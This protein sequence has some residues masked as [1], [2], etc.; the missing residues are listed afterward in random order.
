MASS[1]DG[2][3]KSEPK[4]VAELL[5]TSSSKPTKSGHIEISY[6]LVNLLSEQLYQS[7]AKAIEELVVNAYDADASCCWLHVPDTQALVTTTDEYMAILDDGHG[8]SDDELL[9]LWTIG[10]S[11]K[12]VG[13]VSK[14]ARRYIGKFGIGKLAT[15]SIGKQLTFISRVNGGPIQGVTVDFSAFADTKA[16]TIKT[17]PLPVWKIDDPSAFQ[18]T[19]LFSKVLSSLSIPPKTL[20]KPHWTLAIVE[21]LKPKAQQ[22]TSKKLNWVLSTALPLSTSFSIVLNG[23]PVISAKESGKK[24]AYFSLSELPKTRLDNLQ[25]NTG[26]EWKISKNKLHSDTFPNGLHGIAFVSHKSLQGKSEDLG[27]SYG[28]FVKINNRL[29]NENDE[30]FGVKPKSFETWF[31]FHATVNADDLNP[32]IMASR[33]VVEDSVEKRHLQAVLN[34]IYNEA[35][36]RYQA[37]RDK[38]DDKSQKTKREDVREYVS[39]RMIEEPLA[40]ALIA[41]MGQTDWFYLRGIDDAARKQIVEELYDPN[42][43]Y[44]STFRYEKLGPNTPIFRYSPDTRIF[45]LND[46]H[47]FVREHSEDARARLV[48]EDLVTA[49]LLLEAHL[50]RAGT[51]DGIVVGVLSSRDVLLRNLT[52]ERRY[53]LKSIATALRDAAN[54]EHDLE[55]ALI[56]AARTLGFVAKHVSGAGEPDGTA[57]FMDYP[58]GET[59]LVLEAK[60][61]KN[62]PS[63]GSIDFAGL[64]SHVVRQKAQG[65]LLLAP[66][67]PGSTKSDNEASAR[68]KQQRIS[69]WTIEQMA[70]VIENSETRRIGARAIRDIVLRSFAPEDVAVDVKKLLEEPAWRH[71]EL[72]AAIING[73]RSLEGTAS[74]AQRDT[75]MIVGVLAASGM[76]L[77]REEVRLA[78]SEL[79]AASKGAAHFSHDKDVLIIHTSLDE[80]ENRLSAQLG[81][82]GA[83]RK[84]GP[85]R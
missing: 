40:D 42:K 70:S 14:K 58:G 80:L 33:E 72:Y 74:D 78:V 10:A 13:G 44:R 21:E 60:S 45:Q 32:K 36:I 30:Y 8:M 3:T 28:F 34:E 46:D 81:K 29:I 22:L 79:A 73:L 49:E 64:R 47:D 39:P 20:N 25:K 82:T 31:N 19:P 35:R 7:P 37:A 67:Y 71:Q 16:Q 68:A 53:S 12:S 38:E 51:A 18:K 1:G 11:K 63:L 50:R 6:S 27:R 24:Y 56:A 55:V 26:I 77:K 57:R 52:K 4:T 9:A 15:Y 43:R 66:A 23:K 61:S 48:L 83:P 5:S 75:G 2:T 65:C 17:I 76:K 69:C 85:F 41:P 84:K 62:V 59:L 54:D